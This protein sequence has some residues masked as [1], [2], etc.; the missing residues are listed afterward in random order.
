MNILN[1]KMKFAKRN[2]YGRLNP[3]SLVPYYVWKNKTSK[4]DNV[5]IL[6]ETP[7]SEPID[8]SRQYLTVEMLEDG[9]IAIYRNTYSN[10]KTYYTLDGGE[11]WQEIQSE[12]YNTYQIFIVHEGDKIMLKQEESPDMSPSVFTLSGDTKFNMY[13]NV[14]SI[15]YGDNF[16]GRT[17]IPENVTTLCTFSGTSVVDASNLILPA[18]TLR[19]ASYRNMFNSCEFLTKAPELPATT[20]AD[21]CYYNMFSNCESLTT[22]PELPATTLDDSC[23]HGMFSGCTSLNYVTCLATDISASN[24]TNNWVSNVSSTGT[25]VKSVSMS[26]WTTGNNGIPSGWSVEEV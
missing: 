5:V 3:Q 26:S 12:G 23:Y 13:G 18:T 21:S 4:M 17:E 19:E 7:D 25:F 14:M 8:Y 16:I 11:T 10:S 6:E 24:C 22:A 2:R 9:D 15:A 1:Q 20:L